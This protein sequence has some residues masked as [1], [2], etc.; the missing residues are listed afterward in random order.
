MK[1]AMER[2][3]A[4]FEQLRGAERARNMADSMTDGKFGASMAALSIDFVF[5]S[6][7]AREGLDRRARSL[8]TLGILI[9][10]RQRDELKNH[11]RIALTNGLSMGEIEEVMIQASVYAGFPAAH[12]ASNAA[13]EV[14]EALEIER[15]SAVNGR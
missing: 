5:G 6:V 3:L 8:V 14:L 4:V 13:A 2:G 15:G 10:L 12:T 7:W 9:A 11:V 1:D